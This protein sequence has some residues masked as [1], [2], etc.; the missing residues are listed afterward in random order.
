MNAPG[1][2][3][4][5]SDLGSNFSKYQA[6]GNDYL[7]IDPSRSSIEVC[8]ETAVLMCDRHR[9]VGADGVLWG[10]FYED[11][12]IRLRIFNSDGS[13]CRKSGNGLRI[14]G[15]YLRNQ[16]YVEQDLFFVETVSGRSSVEVI[17]LDAAVFKVGLGAFSFENLPET[18]TG[19]AECIISMPLQIPGEDL[20]VTCV[21]NGNAHC[22]IFDDDVS[23]QRVQRLGPAFSASS[24]FSVKANVALAKIVDPG[25]LV[26][27]IW[28]QGAGYVPASGIGACAV[29]WVAYSFGYVRSDV[30]VRMPG[31]TI[32]VAIAPSGETYVTGEVHHIA[33]GTFTPAFRRLLQK[34]QIT[35]LH[36][37]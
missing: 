6:L 21:R 20:S 4:C 8:C 22:V 11:G 36:I 17:D 12:S 15:H 28:E 16:Q 27:E 24:R 2:I 33:E 35:A 37:E 30:M 1:A 9:G 5:P 32:S 26:A 3:A 31:G 13:E 18:A 25:S 19:R 34:Q 23:P 29:A 10:P 7:V 14:F